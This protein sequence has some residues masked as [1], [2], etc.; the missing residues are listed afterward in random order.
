MRTMSLE[1]P[2][3]PDLTMR[4]EEVLVKAESLTANEMTD[5]ARA[6]IRKIFE[7]MSALAIK[8]LGQ[9]EALD[10]RSD[11]DERV[12]KIAPRIDPRPLTIRP[13]VKKKRSQTGGDTGTYLK[14]R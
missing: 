7:S 10:F 8:E 1:S 2:S 6:H 11:L 5:K 9:D 3:L 13:R 4:L 12:L 14:R